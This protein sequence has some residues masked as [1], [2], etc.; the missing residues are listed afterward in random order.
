MLFG[1]ALACQTNLW[2]AR[3]AARMA[4]LVFHFTGWKAD[5]LYLLRRHLHG[6][7]CGR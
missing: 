3:R 5:C 1:L 4:S 6:A 2:A 7:G